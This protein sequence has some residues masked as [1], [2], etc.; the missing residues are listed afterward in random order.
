MS[1]DL[2]HRLRDTAVPTVELCDEAA[3]EIDR[4][5]QAIRRLA[6]QD[7]TLSVQGG[8]VIVEQDATL[9]EAEREAVCMGME[10]LQAANDSSPGAG[11]RADHAVTSLRRLLQRSC[12]SSCASSCAP[13]LTDAE[14]EAVSEAIKA[15]DEFAGDE[16]YAVALRGLLDRLK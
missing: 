3:G 15:F 7:A 11:R 6:E 5:R 2:L 10:A 14:R 9:T 16:I 4:L 8:N 1:N 12:A 13:T